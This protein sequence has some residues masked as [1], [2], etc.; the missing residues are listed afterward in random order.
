M[1]LAVAT[2]TGTINLNPPVGACVLMIPSLDLGSRGLGRSLQLPSRTSSSSYCSMRRTPY[3]LSTVG[4]P[5]I[6]VCRWVWKKWNGPKQLEDKKTHSLMM[7]PYV[8]ITSLRFVPELTDTCFAERT[9]SSL[10]TR[11]SKS[12]PRRMLTMK[13]SGSRS[14]LLDTCSS[15]QPTHAFA[16]HSFSAAFSKL[17]ELG[18]PPNQFQSS[19]YWTMGDA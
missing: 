13:H 1:L 5:L 4:R 17:L 15:L 7:L 10:K 16:L 3:P 18:V 9:T 2:L 8:S 6:E 12:G 11:A 14:T 19:E